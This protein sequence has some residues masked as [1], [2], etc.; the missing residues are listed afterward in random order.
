MKKIKEFISQRKASLII[1]LVLLIIV[2]SRIKA[3]SS[4]KNE[5]ITESPVVQNIT[6]TLELTGYIDAKE[7][8]NLKFV[9]PS[10]LSWVG[11]KEG[12]RVRKWQAIASVDTRTLQ[13][14]LQLDLNNFAKEFNDHDQSLDN[15]DYY[16][17]SDISTENRRILENAQYDLN[18]SV[19]AVEIRDLAVRLSSIISPING[20]VTRVDQPNAGVNISVTDIFQI[21]NPD[22]MFFSAEVDELDVSRVAVDQ[23]ATLVLDAYEEESVDSSIEFI[24]FTPVSSPTGG[25]SYRVELSL[26]GDNDLLKY[27]LGMS[28]EVEII[29]DQKD[30]VLTI[31]SEAIIER[32]EVSFVEI[33]NGEG[34]IEKKEI[35]IGIQTDDLVE[36]ISGISQNDQVIIPN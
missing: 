33:K 1:A 32:D 21:V 27:R 18:N 3:N 25:T 8:A 13:K 5:I 35:E 15:Y 26:P 22:S 2:G 30:S 28:G 20:I 6:K 29:L 14:Q 24:S 16:G 31:P 19:I 11:V 9:A 12:D 34:N 23:K 36:I 4:Q 7:K 10:R 17:E